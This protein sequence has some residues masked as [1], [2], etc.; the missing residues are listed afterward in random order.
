MSHRNGVSN[1]RSVRSI[2]PLSADDRRNPSSK[3]GHSTST[4]LFRPATRMPLRAGDGSHT[5]RQAGRLRPADVLALSSALLEHFRSRKFVQGFF[6]CR[7]ID[8]AVQNPHV[9]P[10]AFLNPNLRRSQ[11]PHWFQLCQNIFPIGGNLHIEPVPG[12]SSPKSYPFFTVCYYCHTWES[13]LTRPTLKL[14]C[15]TL[16][17]YVC[18][19][20]CDAYLLLGERR[21]FRSAAAPLWGCSFLPAASG[22]SLTLVLMQEIQ[23]R[24]QRFHQ[25]RWSA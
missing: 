19:D 6:E 10:S 15:S 20:A 7:P 13:P 12:V 9:V 18:P 5:S 4:T 16:D 3:S 2:N 22:L 11:V 25:D 24:E 8:W 17:P 1:V 14:F 21:S 23:V